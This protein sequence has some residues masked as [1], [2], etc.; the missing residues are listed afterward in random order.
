[1]SFFNDSVVNGVTKMKTLQFYDPHLRSNGYAEELFTSHLP[2]MRVLQN[3][4][5]PFSIF[6][7]LNW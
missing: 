2:G 1:M 4:Q 5:R 3:L 7:L 6:N